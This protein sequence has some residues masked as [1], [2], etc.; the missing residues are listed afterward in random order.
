MNWKKIMC[1]K[2][3]EEK[4]Q[5]DQNVDAFRKFT[6]FQEICF[7]GGKSKSRESHMN[8]GEFYKYLSDHECSYV[9]RDYFGVEGKTG[10]SAH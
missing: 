5:K 3:E 7:D 4:V 6:G 9:F 10:S 8:M 2:K 1:K